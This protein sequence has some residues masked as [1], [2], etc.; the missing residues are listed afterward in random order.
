MVDKQ[1]SGEGESGLRVLFGKRAALRGDLEPNTVLIVPSNDSWNDFGNYTRVDYRIRVG[2]E[3]PPIEESGFIGFIAADSNRTDR[4]LLEQLLAAAGET[5]HTA[6][7]EHRF[8]T[9]LPDMEAYRRLVQTLNADDAT[10]ALTAVNDLVALSEFNSTA[11]ILDLAV[12]TDA[13]SLSFMRSSDT[14][15]AFKNAGPL[16]RGLSSE[17]T[18]LLSP[19]LS[20]RF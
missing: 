1:S 9:M 15:F 10:A 11:D 13:F 2:A 12:Q 5:T 3:R 18:G 19:N 14:Y 8:F 17:Q 7:S 4:K 16:L 6:R 20:I